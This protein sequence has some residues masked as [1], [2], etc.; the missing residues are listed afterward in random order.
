MHLAHKLYVCEL[1]TVSIYVIYEYL[2]VFPCQSLDSVWKVSNEM[3]CHKDYESFV[4]TFA[5]EYEEV[6]NH[7]FSCVV[8]LLSVETKS[9]Q[10]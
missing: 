1:V 9:Q 3:K 6:K 2:F 4:F 5:S 7:S 10:G 8:R